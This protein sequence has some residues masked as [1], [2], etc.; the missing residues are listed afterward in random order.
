M[1]VPRHVLIA[2]GLGLG[3]LACGFTLSAGDGDWNLPLMALLLALG[4]L[5]EIA[6]VEVTEAKLR[7][8]G[9][10][11]ALVLAM[12]LLGG[13]PAAL[14]SAL[15]VVLTW[16]RTREPVHALRHNVLVFAA[17]ALVG[18]VVFHAGV[19]ALHLTDS[20]P[21]FYLLVLGTYLF[22]LAVNFLLVAGYTAALGR[23]SLWSSLTDGFMPTLASEVVTGL[24][25]VAVTF[26][27]AKAGLPA[28]LLAG[29]AIVGFQHLVKELLISRQRALALEERTHQLHA[30][31][32]TDELTGLGN[33]RRLVEE[34]EARTSDATAERPLLL[35][36]FDLDGFK[37][38]N[39]AFGHPEG[40][41]LLRRL[42]GRLRDAIGEAGEAY[43]PGGDEFCFLADAG[44]DRARALVAA[45]AEALTEH[46]GGFEV[47]SSSGHVVL[48]EETADAAEALRLADQRMYARKE[49]RPA[50]A[51]RQARDLLLSVLA[52]QQPDLH[53]HLSDVGM[54]AVG[55]A[56]E[57]GMTDAEVDDVAR[58]AEL[59]DVGKIA[60]PAAILRKPGPLNDE[61][62]R[63]MRRHTLIGERM[64]RAAPAL[65]GVARLVRSSH[66]RWDGDGYPDRLLGAQIP[67]GSRIITVCDAYD[68]MLARRP[69]NR[70][71]GE[72]AAVQELVDCA[73]AHFDPE[74]VRAFLHCR[75]DAADAHAE[76]ARAAVNP[77]ELRSR[78]GGGP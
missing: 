33:R 44:W 35:A 28:L 41:L 3:G 18:G 36:V 60:I 72:A 2:Q 43:R 34:L 77:F 11:V 1:R 61:E 66:E 73:G 64:L 16:L 32:L 62:W 59:H 12:V 38:Y 9:A 6:S 49:S 15:T 42:G 78:A 21:G 37:Q 40:D 14:L 47:H 68:A 10:F 8:S 54:L 5:S 48:P 20:Q 76:I 57:L 74:V 51:K 27:Y 25:T 53:E 69:Y 19:S 63:Y 26:L 45:G 22:A 31:A 50:S 71:R 52:E 70:Q 75:S 58:A 65:R 55:I 17:F 30:Q 4:T 56:R 46:G 7:L 23:A 13:A 39:D 29:I 24:V 67:L